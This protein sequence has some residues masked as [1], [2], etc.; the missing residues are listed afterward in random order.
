MRTR[1][2][3]ITIGIKLIIYVQQNIANQKSIAKLLIFNILINTM[4]KFHISCVSHLI[5]QYQ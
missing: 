2:Y 1:K 4:Q 5:T 3:N